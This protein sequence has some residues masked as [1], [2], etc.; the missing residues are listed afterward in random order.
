MA[1][2]ASR[3][4]CQNSNREKRIRTSADID[5]R[6]MDHDQDEHQRCTTIPRANQTNVRRKKQEPRLVRDRD[7]KQPIPPCP[8]TNRP[9]TSIPSLPTPPQPKRGHN[10]PL[11]QGRRSHTGTLGT[12]MPRNIATEARSFQ[13]AQSKHGVAVP[14]AAQVTS[15]G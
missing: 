6:R 7:T 11:L 13:N 4:T 15:P 2:Q 8:P 1:E 3:R 10:M 12:T 5:E 14:T 9:L